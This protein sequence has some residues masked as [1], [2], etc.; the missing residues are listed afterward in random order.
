MKYA[1]LHSLVPLHYLGKRLHGKKK[2]LLCMQKGKL[3]L[4]AVVQQKTEDSLLKRS[5][6]K[7]NT[8]TQIHLSFKS[9]IKA[10]RR[11]QSFNQL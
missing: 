10:H 8:K 2:T 3:H 4:F 7:G 11:Q 5:I 6:C 1:Q 9:Q